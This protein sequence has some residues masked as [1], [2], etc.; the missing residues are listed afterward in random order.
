MTVDLV[1]LTNT[2]DA[3]IYEMTC[4][5]LRTLYASEQEHKFNVLLIETDTESGFDYETEFGRHYG[6]RVLAPGT[7]FNYNAYLNFAFEHLGDSHPIVI[8]NN[9]LVFDPGWFSA[10][11]AAMDVYRLSAAS[12][13]SPGWHVHE[14]KYPKQ[15]I[16]FGTEVGHEFCG[17]CVCLHRDALDAIRPLDE[18]FAFEFQDVDMIEQLKL[19]GYG[20]MALVAHSTVTHLVNRSHRLIK[21]R[22]G[23]IE[24]AA[25]IYRGKYGT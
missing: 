10:L 13:R 20:R 4:K 11:Y 5:A 6:L 2:A 17:W 19:K 21:E 22:H 23:M 18:R 9:D 15:G 14:E 25:D 16:Y 3:P 24:G 8:A 7:P 12:P 1:M